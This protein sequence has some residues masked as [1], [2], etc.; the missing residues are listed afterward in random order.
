MKKRLI[1]KQLTHFRWF[2]LAFLVVFVFG[3]GF[4]ACKKSDLVQAVDPEKRISKIVIDAPGEEIIELEESQ[5]GWMV[6]DRYKA[7]EVAVRKL[8]SRLQGFV[9]KRP[10]SLADQQTINE[11]MRQQGVLLEVY[12]QTHWI[13][14]PFN[15]SLIERE[16]LHRAYVVAGI[17][18]DQESSYLRMADSEKVFEVHIPG[19]PEGISGA[20][21]VDDHLW[22]DPTVI[23][24]EASRIKSIEVFVP[25]NEKESFLMIRD[26]DE[27]G[28]AQVF[29]AYGVRLETDLLDT[30]RM[31]RY[32]SLF[33]NIQLEQFLAGDKLHTSLQEMVKPPFMELT[34][35]DMD[36]Q[37]RK[38]SCF[39]RPNKPYPGRLY[40]EDLLFDPN[41]FY[42]K[43]ED[44]DFAI[45]QFLVFNRILR[46]LSFF[47]RNQS[48][49]N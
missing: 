23:D 25:G 4:S 37:C 35:C 49:N 5:D 14:L 36:G 47:L 15:T 20:I 16:K 27:A 3:A 44:R 11:Q 33:K 41:R 12:E 30:I 31:D 42:L 22:R 45:A 39:H 17:A 19:I 13:R 26:Q 6:S 18:K 48:N 40:V 7:N 21:M 29:D 43:I 46:P 2:L 28:G 32:F 8:L 1:K 10:V 9:I 38:I 24:L 34:I